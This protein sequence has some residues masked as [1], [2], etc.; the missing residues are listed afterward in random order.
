MAILQTGPINSSEYTR[1]TPTRTPLPPGIYKG[2]ITKTAQKD[3]GGS[4]GK[5]PGVMVEIEFDITHPEEFSNR[6][7]WDRFNV[8]NQSEKA[9]RI[10]VEALADLTLACGLPVLMDDEELLAH[11]VIMELSI[12]KGKPYTNKQGQQVDG[13]DQNKCEKYWH[14]NT[15][16]DAAKKAQ[17]EQKAA[18]PAKASAATNVAQ[19]WGAQKP[20]AA[21]VQAQAAV[22]QQAAPVQTA[23]APWKRNKQ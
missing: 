11:E 5:A 18:A 17:K 10:S 21:P 1:S 23:T 6:K 4:N 20:A 15:D 13:D 22:A 14:V 9:R 3:T 2:I 8:V 12:E 16:L 7:F 19:K